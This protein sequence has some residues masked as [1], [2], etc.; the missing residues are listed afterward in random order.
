MAKNE[1]IHAFLSEQ[2][3]G[4]TIPPMANIPNMADLASVLDNAVARITAC[5]DHLRA[6]DE[7][8]PD[9]ADSLPEGTSLIGGY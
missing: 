8:Q 2:G 3:A 5:A 7:N 6:L 4:L 1:E 9:F